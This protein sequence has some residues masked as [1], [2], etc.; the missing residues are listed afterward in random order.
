[1]RFRII[2]PAVVVFC[3]LIYGCDR[4]PNKEIHSHHKAENV[5]TQD[6]QNA[7]E[8]NIEDQTRKGNGYFML[9]FNQSELRLKLVRVHTEYLATLA[10]EKHFAC[11]DLVST[12]GDVYDVDFFLAGSPPNMNVTKTSVHKIN[13][14]PIYLWKQ[15]NDGSWNQAPVKNADQKLLG[16]IRNEDKF[17][18]IYNAKLPQINAPA[19]MWI[20]MPITKQFQTVSTKSI[21]I[22]GQYQILEDTDYNNKVFFVLLSPEDSGKTIDIRYDV[23]S[24]EKK[25]SD[26]PDEEIEKFLKPS[27]LVPDDPK[28]KNIAQ[29]VVKDKKGDIVRARALYDHVIDQIKYAKFGQGW[30][31]GDALYACDVKTGNCTDFHSYFIALC[32]AVNIPAKFAIGAAIPSERNEGGIDGYH[33]WA[34]F[35]ADGQWWPVDISEADKYSTLATYYFGHQPANR[36]ELSCGRDIILKE[37]PQSGPINFLA[38]PIIEINS[39]PAK[40]TVK[41]SFVRNL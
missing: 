12:Q 30:G 8:K 32:H 9:P 5:V 6:I 1:M 29:N 40:A 26:A 39:K 10:P 21:E 3:A 13:G 36:I 25:I 18:F 15:K 23:T 20:P 33:C 37:L 17:Q 38:Y 7:I 41:F 22:P 14:K 4:N 2:I 24:K 11:V 27:R 19:K 31:K 35:Y 16:V 34:E 28:F